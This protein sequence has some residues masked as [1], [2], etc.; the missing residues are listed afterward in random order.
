MPNAFTAS[1]HVD[2]ASAEGQYHHFPTVLPRAM[3]PIP[4]IETPAIWYAQFLAKRRR[5]KYPQPAAA[6]LRQILLTRKGASTP[7]P[8]PRPPAR[9][10]RARD[11]HGAPDGRP[12]NTRERNR[13]AARSRHRRTAQAL[14]SRCNASVA[15]SPGRF[16]PYSW[17]SPRRRS[18][19]LRS[20]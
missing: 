15:P 6:R 20:P 19:K 17:I 3:H 2:G 5:F 14:A 12:G 11:G 8:M 4:E 9:P 18:E 13:A 16:M 1:R 7:A 10:A